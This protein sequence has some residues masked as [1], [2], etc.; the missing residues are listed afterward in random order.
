MKGHNVV[1]KLTGKIPKTFQKSMPL[2]HIQ[3]FRVNKK[4]TTNQYHHTA[5]D[6]S[7][8][9]VKKYNVLFSAY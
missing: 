2:Q 7:A 8:C 3:L 9:V 6:D 5:R 4:E 1:T